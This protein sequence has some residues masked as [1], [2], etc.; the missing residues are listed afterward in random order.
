MGYLFNALQQSKKQMENTL[1]VPILQMRKLLPRAVEEEVHPTNTG[2]SQDLR[3]V[4]LA[5]EVAPDP[6][7]HHRTLHAF[8]RCPPDSAP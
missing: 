7:V 3:G 5:V 8:P 6:H 2:E 4:H 1:T